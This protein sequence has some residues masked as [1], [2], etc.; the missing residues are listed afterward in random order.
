M[1][2]YRLN[3][4]L[5][6]PSRSDRIK[7]RASL[8]KK[9]QI[10]PRFP[11]TFMFQ[12]FRCLSW[13]PEWVVKPAGLLSNAYTDARGCF[14]CRSWASQASM[15]TIGLTGEWGADDWNWWGT[16]V[17]TGNDRIWN[18]RLKN[19]ALW[20]AQDKWSMLSSYFKDTRKSAIAGEI[21]DNWSYLSDVAAGK[22]EN[23]WIFGDAS[24]LNWLLC[25]S[26]LGKTWW[27]SPARFRATQRSMPWHTCSRLSQG[28]LEQ[29]Q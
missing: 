14:R 18:D 12:F 29:G 7:K 4:S 22:F 24:L 19:T 15:Y 27:I 6:H 5:S 23:K 11:T 25:Q 28:F 3:Q 17:A 13:S 26:S 21:S 16:L 1:R 9:T 10:F 8:I 2:L 20:W